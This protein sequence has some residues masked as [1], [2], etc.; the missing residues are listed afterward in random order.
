M[1]NLCST[2]FLKC[3]S[4]CTCLRVKVKVKFLSITGHWIPEGVYRYS[5]SLSWPRRLDGDGWSASRPGPLYPRKRPGTHCTGGWVGP[6]AGLEGCGKSRPHRDL[7][8]GPFSP[9]RVAIPTEI[10]WPTCLRVKYELPTHLIRQVNLQ[11]CVLVF[12]M[13]E[14]ES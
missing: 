7:I 5:P 6:R 1:P 3:L 2:L 4:P 13:C 14:M 8:H 10:S 12:F 11:F 9:Q